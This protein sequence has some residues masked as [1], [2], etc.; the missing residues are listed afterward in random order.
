MKTP[1]EIDISAELIAAHQMPSC[2]ISK[3]CACSLLLLL[4]LFCLSP[5]AFAQPA[6]PLHTV[7]AT[8]VDSNGVRVRLKSV[9]WYGTESADFV[10]GGLESAPL[11]SIVAHIKRLGFTTVRLP[12]SNQMYETNPVVAGY[13][14]TANSS[15]QGEN[16]LTILDQVVSALTSAGIMVILDNHNS[17]AE[18]CCS[19]SDG[20]TLWYNSR[21]PESAWIA[22]WQG[23]AARYKNNP[24]VIGADLRNE[25]RTTATWGGDA[26]TDWHAAA[27]RGGNAVLGV[28]PHL[29]IFAEGVGYALDLSGVAALPVQLNV[30]NQLVY[31]A[32]D[33]GF[34]Y[35]GLSS[36]NDYVSRITPRWGYLVTGSP[37]VPLWLGEFGTCNTAVTCVVSGKQIDGGTWFGYVTKFLQSNSVDGSYWP[38]NGTQPTGNG[39]TY[40]APEAYGLLNPAWNGDA[41]PALTAAVAGMNSANSVQFKLTSSGDIAI[42]QPGLSGSSILTIEPRSGF[43]GTVNLSCTLIGVPDNPV[44]LPTCSIPGS[45]VLSSSGATTT[46]VSV[47]SSGPGATVARKG[48]IPNPSAPAKIRG[49]LGP[50]SGGLTLGCLFWMLASPRKARKMLQLVT[51]AMLATFISSCNSGSAPVTGPVPPSTTAGNYIFTVLGTSS[52][53]SLGSVQISVNI[54]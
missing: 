25:P 39:R 27:E 41:L 7:G 49:M 2:S 18:F 35:T 23:M 43:T 32:H 17:D 4:V 38:I 26:S 52:G 9:N 6:F 19:D 42:S 31:S 14:L 51:V 44:N 3:L 24:L 34:D 15:L 29:L 50:V 12:W 10:V 20:N 8:V 48:V 1:K 11:E 13:A 54:Q 46:T 53:L 30:A 36:Y 40:G 37:T 33:Y 21:F 22:D 16:A 28:N 5:S 47:S 45:V